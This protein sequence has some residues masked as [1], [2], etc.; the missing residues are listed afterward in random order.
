[1]Q[2]AAIERFEP[3]TDSRSAAYANSL[4]FR[5]KEMDRHGMQAKAY[6]YP[7]HVRPIPNAPKVFEQS[8][9]FIN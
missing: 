3:K 1:M 5:L 6:R 4:C 8:S 9:P 2:E 7:D